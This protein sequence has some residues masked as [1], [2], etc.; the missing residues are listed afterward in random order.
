[1]FVEKWA[2]LFMTDNVRNLVSAGIVLYK[3]DFKRL[4]KNLYQLK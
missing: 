2:D 4:N 3:P 1:M